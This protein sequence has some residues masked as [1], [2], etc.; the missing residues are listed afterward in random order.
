MAS[1]ANEL[2]AHEGLL[3]ANISLSAGGSLSVGAN[4]KRKE[5]VLRP[6]GSYSLSLYSFSYLHWELAS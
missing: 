3:L 2:L 5:L 1:P 6:H 4:I